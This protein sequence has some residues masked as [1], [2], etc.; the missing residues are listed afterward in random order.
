MTVARSSSGWWPAPLQ[1]PFLR[2]QS[3]HQIRSWFSVASQSTG[4][5]AGAMTVTLGSCMTSKDSLPPAS[6]E[7]GQVK[8]RLDQSA[9]WIVAA[10]GAMALAAFSSA[11]AVVWGVLK[12]GHLSS[13][14]A[15]VALLTTGLA[16]GSAVWGIGLATRFADVTVV[17]PL[18]TRGR[19]GHERPETQ[20]AAPSNGNPFSHS[21]MTSLRQEYIEAWANY[22]SEARA[23]ALDHAL[24]PDEAHLRKAHKWLVTLH[25]VMMAAAQRDAAEKIAED[26]IQL[27][28]RL[29]VALSV[30][31]IATA[32]LVLSVTLRV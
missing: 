13:T 28:R 23:V 9:R 6:N 5:P 20:D 3:C 27:R 24:I 11:G 14:R 19:E 31:L 2:S 7:L 22:L 32:V 8:Q 16:V 4:R 17:D 15:D 18:A 30:S 25:S 21:A 12:G 29:Q 1:Q 10:A 26:W